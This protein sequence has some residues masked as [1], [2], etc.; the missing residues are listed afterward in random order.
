MLHVA[1][2][3]APVRHWILGAVVVFAALQFL[4]K[5]PPRSAATGPVATVLESAPSS[6]RARVASIYS[7]LADVVERD[8]GKLIPTTAVWRAIY[9]DALR[10]AAGGTDLPGKYPGLDKA[11]E[12]VLAQ[13]YPLDNL[14]IDPVLAQ[15]IAT[16]CRAVEKQCE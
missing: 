2:S 15:K 8:G 7:S 12:E 16:A 10:L 3:S 5:G 9:A 13:H 4:P 14:P 1:A 11:I 6:D